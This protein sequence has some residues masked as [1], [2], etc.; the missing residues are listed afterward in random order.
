[1]PKF[2][3]TTNQIKDNKITIVGEDVKHI[4]QVLRAKKNV[5]ITL[6][7]SQTN[8]NYLTT[9]EQITTNEIICNIVNIIQN[10]SESKIQITIFQGLP[11][12]DKLEYLIQK[13]IELGAKTIT[14]VIMKRCVVKW[15]TKKAQAKIE[16]LQKIA[17][18]AAKQSMRDCIPKIQD[19]ITIEELAKEISKFNLVVLAYEEDQNNN[20]KQELKKLQYFEGMKIGIIVGPE[21]GIDKQEVAILKKAGA[22]VITLGRR[23]L[24]TETAAIVI[25]SNIIYEYEM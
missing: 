14:P 4:S 21:G 8:T 5:A 10:L 16:R 20:L 3:I 23:I 9:I 1:M 25:I 13:N 6:C 12:A 11:K 17:V 18:S 2:F 22:K 24:R 19:P 15:D 7:D